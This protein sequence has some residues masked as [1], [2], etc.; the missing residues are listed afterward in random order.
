MIPVGKQ[1]ISRHS[2]NVF[3]VFT[4]VA[5]ISGCGGE[6]DDAP[7]TAESELRPTDPDDPGGYDGAD[8]NFF[9]SPKGHIR[10]WW[11]TEGS[12]QP[13]GADDNQSGIPDYVEL[14]AEIGDEV[15]E[16]VEAEGW[17]RPLTPPLGAPAQEPEPVDLFL[18]DFTAGDGNFR[19]E[20]CDHVDGRPVCAGH[21][22]VDNNFQ[23]LYYPS[24]EYAL[25]VVVSH[26]F[27]HAVQNAYHA[28]MPPWWL[29]AGATWF[30]E[31]YWQEQDDFERLANIYF[32]TPDRSL[33]DRQRGPFDSFA[34]GASI[35]AYFLEQNIG[36]DGLRQIDEAMT[37]DLEVLDAMEVVLGE[38]WVP[39][40][41]AFSHF[42]VW[43]AFTGSRAVEGQGY[44]KAQ[45]FDEVPMLAIDGDAD[46]NWE[47]AV[48]PLAV[49]YARVEAN[50]D[51]ALT[52]DVLEGYEAPMVL[53]V[54]HAE[55]EE[56][57]AFSVL[58]EEEPVVFA[59]EESP[60][61]LV[62]AGSASDFDQATQIQL[63]EATGEADN[64]DDEPVE[65]IV[66][67]D[68]SWDDDEDEG[69]SQGDGSELAEADS[70][71]CAAAASGPAGRWDF[72][73]IVVAMMWGI[74]R[75]R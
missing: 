16:L 26:E 34:Y 39:L 74:R 71:G 37:A 15:G 44:P 72:A 11:A 47:V 29:E 38:L 36:A 27:F 25:R 22:R 14:V 57:G 3:F 68:E 30:Q 73:L 45:R 1:M 4:L 50:R 64:D 10:V 33:H 20:E 51:L 28:E 55:F 61:Y 63:R 31:Y 12:H 24:R 49:R 8:A 62:V 43:N 66:D 21:L 69:G 56:S 6:P 58:V 23:P 48:D 70:G 52:T 35:F 19:A 46:I 17:K 65:E 53:A 32:E 60:L 41:E 67:D 40:D 42:A 18:V 75:R 5:L 7:Q 54:S 13:P 9:E 2:L 59:A